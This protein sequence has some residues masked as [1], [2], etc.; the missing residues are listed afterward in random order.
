MR[1]TIAS[2][3]VFALVLACAQPVF[4]EE[5]HAYCQGLVEQAAA[6][7]RTMRADLDNA[8][9]DEYL[10]IC[11]AVMVFPGIVKAGF[12][13]G[14]QGGNGVLLVRGADGSWTGPAFYTMGGGSFGL[15]IGAQEIAVV[16]TLMN[17]DALLKAIDGDLNLGADAS[18]AAGTADAQGN[19]STQ[20]LA[21]VYYF[22]EAAGVF[23][24]ISL[25]GGVVSSREGLNDDYYGTPFTSRQILLEGA[26]GTGQNQARSLLDSLNP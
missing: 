7:V 26:A 18:V 16:M 24:G 11:R 17:E 25:E 5:D 8:A 2:L 23:A 13:W 15:Q 20:D 6:T 22:A 1:K 10:K 21:D 14:G 12:I 9:L 4:A 3:V 19:I